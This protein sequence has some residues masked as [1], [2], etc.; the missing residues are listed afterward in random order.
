MY[1]TLPAGTRT[2]DLVDGDIMA[3]DV[4]AIRPLRLSNIMSAGA[5]FINVAFFFVFQRVLLRVHVTI[6]RVPDV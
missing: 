5:T 4:Q 3:S 2:R 1:I 6:E